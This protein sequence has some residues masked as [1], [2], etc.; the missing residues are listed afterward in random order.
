MKRTITFFTLFICLLLSAAV[1]NAQQSVT[2]SA[3]VLTDVSYDEKQDVDFG[4]INQDITANPVL[5]PEAGGTHSNV[6]GTQQLGYVL[7]SG[8]ADAGFSITN[9][10]ATALTDADDFSVDFTPN[11][12]FDNSDTSGNTGCSATA[13]GDGNDVTVATN[14]FSGTGTLWIGGS[15]SNP[16]DDSDQATTSLS[17]GTYSGTISIS[18][19]YA[20]F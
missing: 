3:E 6:S 17:G 16:L 7:F 12:C 19:D 8:T 5:D 2:A 11:F 9:P 10:G 20:S 18:V 13:E 14:N 1:T 15:L 4:I